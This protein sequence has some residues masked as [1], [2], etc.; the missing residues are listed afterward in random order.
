VKSAG[1]L[2]KDQLSCGKHQ[3]CMKVEVMGAVVS[4]VSTFTL[5]KRL[6]FRMAPGPPAF[7]SF[8][9]RKKCHLSLVIVLKE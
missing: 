8:L 6:A 2:A 5:S 4:N 9:W 7:C 3:P 1:I